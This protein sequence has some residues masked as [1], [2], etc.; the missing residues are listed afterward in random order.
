MPIVA[1]RLRAQAGEEPSTTNAL[2]PAGARVAGA[3]EHDVGVGVAGV[4][5]EALLPVEHPRVAV[6][7]GARLQRGGVGADAGSVSA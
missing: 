3:R 5:D 4:A 2:M 6:A 7:L 1:Q